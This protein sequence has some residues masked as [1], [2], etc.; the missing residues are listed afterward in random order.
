[1]DSTFS[2][3]IPVFCDPSGLKTTVESI[4]N[5][6]FSKEC[7]EII[8][9]D[10][11]STDNTLEIAKDYARSYPNLI[12][13]HEEKE[14]RSSYA[15]RNK[16]ILSSKGKIIA[17]L[18]ANV[19]V[20]PDYLSK[21][22]DVFFVKYQHIQYLGCRVEIVIHNRTISAI[23]N[24]AYDFKIGRDIT[25]NNYSPTCSLIIRKRVIDVVGLF[26][27]RLESGGDWDFGQKV[28]KA[29]LK[30][31]YADDIIVYHPAR[32]K[33]SSLINK[34]KRVARGIAQMSHYNPTDYNHLFKRYFSLMR[35]MPKNPVNIYKYFNYENKL[36]INYFQSFI[37][38]FIHI[39]IRIIAL[40][41]LVTMKI[42]LKT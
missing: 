6:D 20:S 28:Y 35:Y 8:I 42:R 32:W 34:S 31:G 3:I 22:N 40:Y 30:Q 2:I 13:F 17:F 33:Y 1:L 19:S 26:D 29:G 27:G 37:L 4:L 25:E 38:S 11:G 10:N 23:Y 16:G 7:Y 12:S 14:I 18:D 5:Q 24:S 9:V 39:P 41:S 15:A 36:G 21:A